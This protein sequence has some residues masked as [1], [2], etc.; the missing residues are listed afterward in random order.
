MLWGIDAACEFSDGQK[1]S[2]RLIESL[3]S[4]LLMKIA[5]QGYK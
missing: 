2:S 5:W 1:F 3:T 4:T